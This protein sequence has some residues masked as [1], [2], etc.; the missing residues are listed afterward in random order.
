MSAAAWRQYFT[1]NRYT[2]ICARATRQALKEEERVKA[3]RRG[4]Q[5]LRFQEWKDGKAGDMHNMG[6]AAKKN[7]GGKAPV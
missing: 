4:A 1:Y 6:D 2:S 3:E 5:A 7:D